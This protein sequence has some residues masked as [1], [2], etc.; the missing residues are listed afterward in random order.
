MHGG[1]TTLHK[2]AT[3]ADDTQECGGVAHGGRMTRPGVTTDA[4]NTQQR[5]GVAHS[6]HYGAAVDGATTASLGMTRP[7]VFDPT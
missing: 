2:V 1:R 7:D 4:D 6:G 5:G 3:D